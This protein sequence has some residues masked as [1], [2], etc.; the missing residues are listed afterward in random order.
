MKAWKVLGLAALAVGLTPT[1]LEKD[2][3]SHTFLYEC[4]LCRVKVKRRPEEEVAGTDL[5][6]TDIDVQLVPRI[7]CP[8]D[9]EDDF[10]FDGDDIFFPAEEEPVV[11][12]EVPEDPEP[13]GE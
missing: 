11:E 2:E 1:R 5:A 13:Q 6:K 12:P 4:L 7:T 9:Y 8:E 3:E 10:D